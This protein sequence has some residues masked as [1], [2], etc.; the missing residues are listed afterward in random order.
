MCYQFINVYIYE[1]AGA[2]TIVVSFPF[3]M[4][5]NFG[6]LSFYF[7][8]MIFMRQMQRENRTALNQFINLIRYIFAVNAMYMTTLA[9][10]VCKMFNYGI[11]CGSE[12]DSN[13]KKPEIWLC[14]NIESNGT[15]SISGQRNDCHWNPVEVTI[16][17]FLLSIQ[18]DERRR[19]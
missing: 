16:F 14:Q 7:W 3:W 9:E 17:S 11:L 4:S 18:S 13:G 5:F 2:S 19:H 15:C 1:A 6:Q 10:I 12:T 8:M